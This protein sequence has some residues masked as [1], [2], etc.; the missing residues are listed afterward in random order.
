MEKSRECWV[1]VV[2]RVNPIVLI[3]VTIE[4]DRRDVGNEPVTPNQYTLRLALDDRQ[5]PRSTLPTKTV[6]LLALSVEETTGPE[7]QITTGISFA[8]FTTVRLAEVLE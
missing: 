5:G 1:A 3:P 6:P 2:S 4:E 8:L 7:L